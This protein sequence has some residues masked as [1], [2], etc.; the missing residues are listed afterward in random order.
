MRNPVK[1]GAVAL[2]SALCLFLVLATP[3]SAN[4]VSVAVTG[5]SLTAAGNTFDLGPN[6]PAGPCEDKADTLQAEFGAT[7]IRL[8]GG[9]SS[10]FQLGTPPS[11]QWYQADFSISNPATAQFTAG[12]SSAGPPTWTYNVATVAPLHLIIKVDIYRIGTDDCVKD[13]LACTVNVRM[14][15]TGTLTSTTALAT[16][17]PGGATLNGASVGNMTV[18]N[19]SAP[20]A[21]WAGQSASVSGMTLV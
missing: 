19:C 18:A 14:S 21:S 13:D 20:F 11:G 8:F 9:W 12:L 15:F 10:Q 7:S 3:A 1:R 2:A 5:G 16:Y 17:T 6:G 4:T